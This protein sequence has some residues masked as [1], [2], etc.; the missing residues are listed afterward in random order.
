MANIL[1]NIINEE[2]MLF[3]ILETKLETEF[4]ETRI[5]NGDEYSFKTNG[6]VEYL[7]HFFYRMLEYDDKIGDKNVGDLIDDKYFRYS[8]IGC[9]AVGYT[10]GNWNGNPNEYS[11]DTN[12][13]EAIELF[14]RISYLV[15]VF[16]SKH[17]NNPI[18]IVGNENGD[19]RR[20]KLY[21]LLYKNIFNNDFEMFKGQYANYKNY[22]MFFI[23]KKVLK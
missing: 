4:T 2:I 14:S 6:G 18:Y 21:E 22:A 7:L 23:S 5:A 11:I 3:E 19:E 16:K 10:L 8:R 12:K 1:K 20:L 17:V 9:V 15:D 13:H